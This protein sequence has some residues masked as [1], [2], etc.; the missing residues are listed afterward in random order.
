MSK[1]TL[2]Y[3]HQLFKNN[4][5]IDVARKVYLI[6]EPLLL[7]YNPIHKAKL[8]LHKL[9]MDYYQTHLKDQ[10]YTVERIAI[11]D[12][13][14]TSSIFD[15]L[16]GQGIT[17]IHV[18]DT[19]D[20]YLEK[21]ISSSGLSRV[22]YDSPNFLLEKKEAIERFRKS[23]KFMANY[24][25]TLRKDMNILMDGDQ[26]TGGKWSFDEDNRKKI[27]KNIAIPEEPEFDESDIV[28]DAASWANT[29][30][31]ESYG[32]ACCWLPYTHEGAQQYLNSFFQQRFENFGAYEDALTT[33]GTRLWHSALSPLLNIGLLS[34][35]DIINKALEYAS[36]SA[37]PLNS[38]EGFIRQIMGWREFIRASYEVD[39]VAMRTQNFWNHKRVLPSSFWLATTD[40]SP[41]DHSI[42]TAL[43][44]GYNHH[45]ERLMIM[46]NFMLLAQVRPDD[47]YKW[48]MSMYLDAYD[49]VMVPNV[50]GMSQFSDGGSFATKPY[51]SGANYIKKMSDYKGGDWEGLWTG[52]YWNF[53]QSNI[54]VFKSNHRLSMMPRLLE[55]MNADTRMKHF[56]AAES[57]LQTLH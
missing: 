10:G 14:T 30:E 43:K 56:Q 8:V 19:V 57:Y 37:V 28:S 22:W 9:S 4:P 40:V 47:V 24:Y 46:G 5:A 44:Y 21:A 34:P 23:K 6:E 18:I 13:K 42:K 26:P 12:H 51:I 35:L 33:R 54:D 11:T 52:L 32:D 2:I 20:Y 17:E 50:Y 15:Y 48:F 16:S 41:L 36:N 31:C 38:L 49:W 53:I 3:P 27:P 45:I 7:S 39:G 55:R 1:A 25:K 29:V